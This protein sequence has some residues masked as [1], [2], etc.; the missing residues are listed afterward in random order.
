M[1]QWNAALTC[2]QSTIIV[3]IM[4]QQYG[5][6]GDSYLDYL[7]GVSP[8][9]TAGQTYQ[10]S[11][12]LLISLGLIKNLSKARPSS[13]RHVVIGV[14]IDTDTMTTSITD[15][16]LTKI[17]SFLSSWHFKKYAR[18]PDLQSLTLIQTF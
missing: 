17:K 14:L 1:G 8:P 2:N 4:H 9:Q 7:I 6:L 15:N 11:H 13:I 5:H 12:Q 3:M 10:S 16:C 18:K